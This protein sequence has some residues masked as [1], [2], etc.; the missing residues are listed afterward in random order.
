MTGCKEILLGLIEAGKL[1]STNDHESER[2][3]KM[4]LMNGPNRSMTVAA[5]V[6]C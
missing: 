1:D 5:M 6:W 3:Y 2:T 4:A